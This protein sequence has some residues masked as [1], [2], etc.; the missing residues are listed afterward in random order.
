MQLKTFTAGKSVQ[1]EEEKSSVDQLVIETVLSAISEP[2]LDSSSEEVADIKIKFS[3]SPEN[4]NLH[5][6]LEFFKNE[7]LKDRQLNKTE[8]SYSLQNKFYG[9]YQIIR[10]G[11]VEQSSGSYFTSRNRI[12]VVIRAAMLVKL[13]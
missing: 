3:S 10:A 9:F 8:K 7:I 13:C 11:L 12:D 6:I 5:W 4:K 1:E 2:G